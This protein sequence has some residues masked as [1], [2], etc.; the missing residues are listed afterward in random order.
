MNRKWLNEFGLHVLALAL[1]VVSWVLLDAKHEVEDT[2]SI[3]FELQLPQDLQDRYIITSQSVTQVELRA[4]GPREAVKET[5]LLL[6][7]FEQNRLLGSLFEIDHRKFENLPEDGGEWRI[8]LPTHKLQFQGGMDLFVVGEVTIILQIDRLVT[9]DVPIQVPREFLGQLPQ[10]YVGIEPR[11]LPERVP[12]TGPAK[13]LNSG[14]ALTTSKLRLGAGDFTPENHTG[15]LNVIPTMQNKPIKTINRILVEVR[16]IPGEV[17]WV[18]DNI[19]I[20]CIVILRR[21]DDDFTVEIQRGDWEQKQHSVTL[22]GPAPL[23]NEL[24]QRPE[25]VTFQVDLSQ[26]SDVMIGS[27]YYA[28]VRVKTPYPDVTAQGEPSLP[29]TIAKAGQ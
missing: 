6:Q 25:L 8:E 11:C 23:I 20:N 26:L 19:D 10:G 18:I 9:M 17:E 3:H 5:T 12:V 27:Y 16:F 4:R 1:A 28:P 14:L 22:K 29:T 24:K 15:Y 21:A 2:I 7:Y 13:L